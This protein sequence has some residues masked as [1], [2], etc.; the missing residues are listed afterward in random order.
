MFQFIRFII[1]VM[2]SNKLGASRS[3]ASFV[4]N[5]ISP[6]RKLRINTDADM[7]NAYATEKKSVRWESVKS[8]TAMSSGY[9][10]R[11]ANLTV[12]AGSWKKGKTTE[13]VVVE[14]QEESEPVGRSALARKLRSERLRL[15]EQLKQTNQRLSKNRRYPA[16]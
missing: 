7:M 12:E 5:K 16:A 1:L 11:Q 10:S 15:V 9:R 13:S 2:Y 14:D 6:E 4:K 3:V 8:P